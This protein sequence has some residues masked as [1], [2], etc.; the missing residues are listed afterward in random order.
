MTKTVPWNLKG[1]G[2]AS[3]ETAREAARRDGTSLG[4]WLDRI[5]SKHTSRLDQADHDINGPGSR[6]GGAAPHRSSPRGIKFRRGAAS[7]QANGFESGEDGEVLYPR[8]VRARADSAL[9]EEARSFPLRRQ[10]RP[11]PRFAGSHPSG[12][13]SQGEDEAALLLAEASA[14]RVRRAA[15]GSGVD[16]AGDRLARLEAR[17]EQLAALLEAVPREP[18]RN[19]RMRAA[20]RVPKGQPDFASSLAGDARFRD[21]GG[22][23]GAYDAANRANAQR[24][25]LENLRRIAEDFARNAPRARESGLDDRLAELDRKIGLAN[26]AAAEALHTADRIA[27]AGNRIEDQDAWREIAALQRHQ[28]ISDN[29]MQAA[30]N[31]IYE[32]LETMAGHL[33]EPEPHASGAS[34]GRQEASQVWQEPGLP[35]R[36][37]RRR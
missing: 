37:T 19:S 5:I 35:L 30:L 31:A 9:D 36:P 25:P 22:K 8:F 11:A 23:R 17:L 33:F 18:V 24:T 34:Q 13:S 10:G 2:L 12:R 7:P 20:S 32:V 16:P 29:R 1:V 3:R 15:Q 28:A 26:E 27:E 14:E 21:S 6:H 4:E